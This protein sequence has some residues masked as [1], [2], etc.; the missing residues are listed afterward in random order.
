MSAGKFGALRSAF[1]NRNFAIYISC[2]SL[3]LIGYWMQRIAVMW[4]TWEISQSAF[5]VGAVAFAEICPLIVV[6]PP[7]GVWADRFDR[8]K[9]AVVIQILMLLQSLLLFTAIRFD[10]LTI[11]LLFA[12]TLIEGIIQAAYQP[13]RLAL[14]PNMVRKQDLVSAAAFTAV[15]FNVARFVGPAIAGVVFT[16]SGPDWMVLFNALTY[17]LLTVAWFSIHLPPQAGEKHEA[18]GLVRDLLDGLRYVAARPALFALFMVLTINALFARPLTYLFSAFTGAVYQAGPETLA[19]F[20]SAVGVGAIL[21][22]LKLS[23]DGK[24]RGL[25]R[26][27]LINIVITAACMAGFAFT[28]YKPLAVVLIFLFGYSITVVTVAAQTLVQ[29]SVDDNMRGRVLSLWVAFTRGAPAV[30]VLVIGWIANHIGLMWP[31]AGAALLCLG[32]MAL[33]LKRRREM[34]GFFESD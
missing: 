4:L 17:G 23:M 25:I 32:G 29:N 26:S 20:T 27:I 5:W 10:V 31:T 30:G 13:V 21:A 11:G 18:R 15:T 3:S 19:L 6:G 34:R 12:L 1:G 16:Y 14:I 28:T 7:F 2:N 33:M 9:L 24:T 8:R 22:G